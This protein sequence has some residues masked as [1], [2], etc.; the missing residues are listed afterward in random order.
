MCFFELA[1]EGVLIKHLNMRASFFAVAL[2]LNAKC[3]IGD[4]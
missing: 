2:L 1:Q 4:Q 3:S